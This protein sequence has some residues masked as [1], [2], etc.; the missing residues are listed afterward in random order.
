M[1]TNR[2]ED[3]GAEERERIAC[4]V[5]CRHSLPSDASRY[6]LC[7]ILSARVVSDS[8]TKPTND[9]QH[10]Q[11]RWI[12]ISQLLSQ[13]DSSACSEEAA[14]E[15]RRRSHRLSTD[16]IL[17]QQQHQ[18]RWQNCGSAQREEH[19]GRHSQALHVL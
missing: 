10:R 6:E 19:E 12:G 8:H 14:D 1:L 7:R 11:Q 4:D 5:S 18:A 16:A 2:V 15:K 17:K 13:N 3:V 9:A